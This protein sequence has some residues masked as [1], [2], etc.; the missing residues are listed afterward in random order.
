MHEASTPVDATHLERGTPKVP[1]T[2]TV[3]FSD[4]SP[5]SA[6]MESQ[7]ATIAPSGTIPKLANRQTAIRSL[8]AIAMMAIR[9]VRP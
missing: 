8:R 1:M 3:A 5:E 7:A 9:R 4:P 2:K 6:T